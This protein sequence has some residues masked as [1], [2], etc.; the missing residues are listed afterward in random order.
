M[1]YAFLGLG[2]N[3]ASAS[4]NIS[5]AVERIR[6]ADVEVEA[7]S[8]VYQTQSPYYNMVVRVRTD[9]PY[10]ALRSLTKGIETEMGRTPQM[11]TL[12]VVPID[13]DVV[14]YDGRVVRPTDYEADYFRMG[15]HAVAH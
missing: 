4:S 13:I 12:G 11:K 5:E 1:A 7:V 14:V 10:E 9:C 3:V 8:N 6:R 15:Y 2:S